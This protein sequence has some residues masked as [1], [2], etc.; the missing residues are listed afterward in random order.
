MAD[1][2]L[3]IGGPAKSSDEGENVD[4]VSFYPAISVQHEVG[5][6]KIRISAK[7]KRL[8][9]L[10]SLVCPRRELKGE[11][12]G[13]LWGKLTRRAQKLFE[14]RVLPSRGH[15]VG[16]GGGHGPRQTLAGSPRTPM[17]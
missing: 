3:R 12:R 14:V 10:W 17:T 15:H 7:K 1:E 6:L 13:I 2:G 11:N 4:D 16:T 5:G 8:A 9:S